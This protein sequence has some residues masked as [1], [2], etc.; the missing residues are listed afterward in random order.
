LTLEKKEKHILF[1]SDNFPPEV[2][3]PATR[4]YEHCKEWVDAGMKV[5][6]ITCVPNFPKGKVFGGYK[7]KLY[8][9]E[10]VDGIEVIRIWSYISA[11]SGFFKRVF[12]YISFAIMAFFTSFIVKKVDIVIATSPQ[13]FSAVSGYFIGL[14]KRKPWIMEVRDIWPESIRAVNAMKSSKVLDWLEKLELF[15]YKKAGKIIVVTDTFKDLIASRGIDKEKI[16]VVKNGVYLD[17]FKPIS[18]D[19]RLLSKLALR[20]K[21]VIGYIG[22]HGMAHKLGFILDAITGMDENIHFLFIGDGSEK[23]KLLLKKEKLGL[24]NITFIAFVSKQEIQKYISITDVALVP[25]KKSETFKTVIPSKIFENAAM[26]KPVLLGVEGESK[27]IIEKYKA[28]LCFVPENK[29]SFVMQLNRL[30]SDK[31]LYERCQKGCE[32]LAYD[33][34]RKKKAMEMLEI[35]RKTMEIKRNK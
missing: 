22:T 7:N 11:N 9:K 2:N 1:I 16:E 24:K 31:A 4:T 26:Q 33:F 35:I 18:K 20:D 21:F 3:A 8:Q 14:F 10:Y 30:Y 19:L 32:D 17:K 6:V 27:K 5:T 15:L 29:D 13:F 12:D 23:Q 28:G 25:L 34:N